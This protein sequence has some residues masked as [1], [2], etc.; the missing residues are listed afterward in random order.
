MFTQTWGFILMIN[1]FL[2]ILFGGITLRNSYK[3]RK[4]T[5]KYSQFMK[6]GFN[7]KNLEQ[8]IDACIFN[9]QDALDKNIEIQNLV[10]KLEANML[11]SIQKIGLVRYSAFEDVGG[12]QSFSVAILDTLDN[13]IV[14]TGLYARENSTVYVKNIESG[15]SMYTLTAE[16]IQ[17]IDKAKRIFGERTYYD[18]TPKRRLSKIEKSVI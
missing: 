11:K 15:K 2:I 5:K 9:S 7:E 16:E 8:L 6:A 14:F 17:A 13:G 18:D 10:N 12:D 3:I 4:F 1:S